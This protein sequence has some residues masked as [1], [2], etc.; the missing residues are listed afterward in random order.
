M[1]RRTTY[2]Y[3]AAALLLVIAAM[4]LAA[5]LVSSLNEMHQRFARESWALGL[6]FLVVLIV[7]LAVGALWLTGLAW[8]SRS[9][10]ADAKPVPAD[11]IQAAT[12]QAD[13]AEGVIRRVGDESAKAELNRELGE[14]RSG[15]SIASS[16]SSFSVQ[17][18]R[19]R[20]R[21][22]TPS[23]ARTLARPRP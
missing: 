14:L 1:T 20:P 9:R 12:L 16:T 7:L 3:A 11:V 8:R 10:P 21:S 2:S 13:Q 4:G 22:S 5:W 18:R 6:A 19:A 15:A 17:G 23:S